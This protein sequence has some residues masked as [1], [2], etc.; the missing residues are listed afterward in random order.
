MGTLGPCTHQTKAVTPPLH[1]KTLFFFLYLN[2]K[3]ANPSLSR[4]LQSPSPPA[5]ASS[6]YLGHLFLSLDHLFLSLDLSRPPSHRHKCVGDSVL[7]DLLCWSCSHRCHTPAQVATIPIL[8]SYKDI[9]IDAATCFGKTPSLHHAPC[10]D[11]S[12]LSPPLQNPT[13]PLFFQLFFSNLILLFML[14]YW[15]LILRRMHI[16]LM[17]ERRQF[18]VFIVTNFANQVR[19]VTQ[20]VMVHVGN[21][22]GQWNF[23]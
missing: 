3:L 2:P 7:P 8:C 20:S 4:C 5:F 22:F 12:A 23:S 9:A 16:Y 11:L 1:A 6:L 19:R 17:D 15:D 13:R 21:P 18:E 14:R 10:Q